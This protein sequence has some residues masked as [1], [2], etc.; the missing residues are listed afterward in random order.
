MPE[1]ALPSQRESRFALR[2][3]DGGFKIEALTW[4]EDMKGWF[5]ARWLNGGRRFPTREAARDFMMA[6]EQDAV[7]PS[8]S[9]S[10]WVDDTPIVGHCSRCGEARGSMYTCR[11]GGET[12]PIA[13]AGG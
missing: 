1:R 4:D 11:D 8:P 2:T 6:L 12:I 13:E 3:V 5:H 10:P 7:S 9:P